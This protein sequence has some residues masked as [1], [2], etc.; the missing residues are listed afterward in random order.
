MSKKVL[1]DLREFPLRKPVAK[2][3]YHAHPLYDNFGTMA[4]RNEACEALGLDPNFRYV[5]FFGF[6]RHYKGLDLLLEAMALLPETLG[7]V[8]LLVAGEF[9][10]DDAPYWQ[11]LKSKNLEH[12][13]EMHT[14]FIP[15]DDVRLYFSASDLVAQPYRNATQSGVSQIAYHFDLP[16]I[17][18]NVGGLSELVP[19]G[20]A[21]WVCEPTPQALA[22]SMVAMYETGRLETMRNNIKE[23][24]KQFSWPSMVQALAGVAN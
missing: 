17:I 24:K 16:M 7:D 18:T 14:K 2:T 20:E 10:E 8:K 23:L 19:H 1:Q 3:G 5:L 6:I 4:Q 21:G 13:V 22:D 12:Q 11:I 15:N 9:Y